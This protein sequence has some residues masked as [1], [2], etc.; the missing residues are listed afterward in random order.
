M[1]PGG[2]PRSLASVTLSPQLHSTHLVSGVN[3]SRQSILNVIPPLPGL[4]SSLSTR[5]D[6]TLFSRNN[7]QAILSLARNDPENKQLVFL[8]R[9]RFP[10]QEPDLKNITQQAYKASGQPCPRADRTC[11]HSPFPYTPKS[12][13]AE[14]MGWSQLRTSSSLPARRGLS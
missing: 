1:R 6:F 8:P 10:K 4:G 14:L 3:M 7:Y 5:L 9:A 2:H 12:V 11:D 13:P